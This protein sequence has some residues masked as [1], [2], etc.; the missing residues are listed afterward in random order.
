MK[1]DSDN[2]NYNNLHFRDLGAANENTFLEFFNQDLIL[3]EIVG[4]DV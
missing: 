4:I 2:S 3:H 1:S